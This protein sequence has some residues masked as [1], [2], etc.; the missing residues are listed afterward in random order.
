MMQMID[1][2][3]GKAGCLRSHGRSTV[4]KQAQPTSPHAISLFRVSST[5]TSTKSGPETQNRVLKP[6]ASS[7]MH[8]DRLTL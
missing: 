1:T 5:A 2:Q 4:P 3:A 6:R 7:Q 8:S